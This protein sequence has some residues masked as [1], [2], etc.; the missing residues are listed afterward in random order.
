[1]IIKRYLIKVLKIV[2]LKINIL[3]ILNL[4]VSQIEMTIDTVIIKIAMCIDLARNAAPEN[5]ISN[6]KR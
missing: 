4:Y 3:K 2:F 5:I 1:M 6:I